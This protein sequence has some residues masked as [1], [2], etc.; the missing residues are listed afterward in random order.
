MSWW[1]VTVKHIS[2][3]CLQTTSRWLAQVVTRRT[4]WQLQPLGALVQAV[5]YHGTLQLPT[6]W[7]T[8]KLFMFLFRLKGGKHVWTETVCQNTWMTSL[9][10]RLRLDISKMLGN[11]DQSAAGFVSQSVQNQKCNIS[12][13]M[14]NI[15]IYISIISFY[16]YCVLLDIN[17][18]YIVLICNND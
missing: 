9:A 16:Y 11:M 17:P 6:F 10:N 13:F 3:C 12:C 4:L 7:L 2:I 18:L 5:F 14:Y 8:V 15:C 1:W